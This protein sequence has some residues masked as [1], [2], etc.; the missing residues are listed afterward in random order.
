MKNSEKKV[1]KSTVQPTGNNELLVK[2]KKDAASNLS[3][4]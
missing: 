3:Q 2:P 4:K 1:E